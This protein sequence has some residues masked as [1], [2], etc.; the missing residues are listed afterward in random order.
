VEELLKN[1]TGL[2][3][4]A[5]LKA[6]AAGTS[7]NVA[8]PT[9]STPSVNWR[10]VQVHY[11]IQQLQHPT[12]NLFCKCFAGATAQEQRP[13]GLCDSPRRQH[14]GRRAKARGQRDQDR[15]RIP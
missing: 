13:I 15:P 3:D 9:A 7:P 12:L 10:A 8:T 6:I 14:A 4:I 1:R 2:V 5:E 11:S